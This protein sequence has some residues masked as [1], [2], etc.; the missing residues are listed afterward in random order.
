MARLPKLPYH[1]TRSRPTQLAFGVLNHTATAADG[2]IYDERDVST[3][4]YPALT[5][6]KSRLKASSTISLGEC[7]RIGSDGAKLF[8]HSGGDLYYGGRLVGRLPLGDGV[9][10]RFACMG[11]RIVI[12]PDKVC[13]DS[14]TGRMTAFG[15]LLA[16]NA[17][18][19]H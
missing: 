14:E 16:A 15:E 6:R 18:L 13:Y 10:R 8:W 5:P 2:E 12:W 7:S 4:E 11:E 9:H 17:T 19:T 3:E 1:L